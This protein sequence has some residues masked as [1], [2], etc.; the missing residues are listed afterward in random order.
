MAS[1]NKS[2][3][4]AAQGLQDTQEALHAAR[5]NLTEATL[6][7]YTD[8]ESVSRIAERTG[9]TTTEVWNTLA[10]HGITRSTHLNGTHPTT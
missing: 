6:D 1:E 7:A 9:R 8:G 3:E 2:L 4:A 10:V 5:R